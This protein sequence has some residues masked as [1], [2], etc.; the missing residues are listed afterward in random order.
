MHVYMYIHT[1]ISTYT[2]TSSARGVAPRNVDTWVLDS[3]AVGVVGAYASGRR[4]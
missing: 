1:Y 2:G 4:G 3:Q